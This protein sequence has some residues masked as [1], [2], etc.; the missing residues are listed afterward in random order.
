MVVD[1]LCS[2][3]ITVPLSIVWRV[4]YRLAALAIHREV[5]R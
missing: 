2:F 5:E 4:R 3:D 1:R